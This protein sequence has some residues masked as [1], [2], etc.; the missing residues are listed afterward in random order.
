[1]EFRMKNIIGNFNKLILLVL[2]STIL[3]TACSKKSGLNKLADNENKI[4]VVTSF[5]VVYDFAGKIGG[6]KVSVKNLLPAGSDPHGWE[7][8][9]K[10][11]INI[12]KA[13]IFI[14][15]GAN[16]EG[17]VDKVLESIG[18]KN[19]IAVEASKDVALLKAEDEHVQEQENENEDEDEHEHLYDPHVWLDPMMAKIQMKSITEALVQF[20]SDNA[21][22][23]QENF[24]KYSE[25]LDK[26]DKE[27]KEAILSFN[28]KDIVVSHEAFGYLCLAYGLNQVGISGLDA[29]AE[30]TASRMVEVADFAKDNDVSVIFF[31]K[32]VNPKIADTIASSTDAKVDVLNPISSLSQKE[33][34][35]GKDYF[36]IMRE[37]LEALKRALLQ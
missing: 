21:D 37:N 5:Y 6:D 26:L 20:D 2:I 31:D 22:Y 11:I 18:N 33:I 27:Y 17:W 15:N 35:E 1:M 32:M 34:K 29:E 19:L 3:F 14:Y 13:D 16:M 25:E 7:P 30:P 10:D 36:A 12:E 4:S 8:S 28:K 23:Y 9:P 24:E